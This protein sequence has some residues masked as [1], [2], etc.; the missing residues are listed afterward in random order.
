[1]DVSF[2]MRHRRTDSIRLKR[3]QKYSLYTVLALLFLSGLAWAYW[4]YLC[5]PGDLETSA[6][7]LGDENPWCC[8][9][10]GF[11]ADWN[12]FERAR[13][14]RVAC[15][16]KSS[17]RI[18]FSECVCVFNYHRLRPLLRGWRN[19]ACVDKLDSSRCRR[20]F[21]H[22]AADPHLS[23]TENTPFGSISSLI[24]PWVSG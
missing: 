7:D 9:D 10:G 15:A 24:A 12:A 20:G 17:K 8:G 23:G 19:T 1:M 16:P 22:L 13:E 3:L 18:G 11:S 6:E 14:I 4:N 5:S 2:T 21:A